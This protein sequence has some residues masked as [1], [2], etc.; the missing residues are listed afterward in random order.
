VKKLNGQI[1][2]QGDQQI[3]GLDFFNMYALVV[4]WSIMHPLLVLLVILGLA[5]K[6]VDYTLAF[7][8]AIVKE[9]AFV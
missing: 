8:H 5:T 1:C 4:A 9:D 2:V 7:V 6:Q 3:E